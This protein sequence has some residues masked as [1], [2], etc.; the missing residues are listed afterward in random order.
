MTGMFGSLS[1]AE[2]GRVYPDLDEEQ[3]DPR[4]EVAEGLVSNQPCN[5]AWHQSKK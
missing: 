3:L 4:D 5:Q 2:A 1:E